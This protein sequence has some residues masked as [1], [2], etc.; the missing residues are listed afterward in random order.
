MD[1]TELFDLKIKGEFQFYGL[2]VSG[3]LKEL[4]GLDWYAFELG[5]I[6]LYFRVFSVKHQREV[7]LSFSSSIFW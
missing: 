4:N 2:K 7:E 1:S 6:S 5:G 3:G